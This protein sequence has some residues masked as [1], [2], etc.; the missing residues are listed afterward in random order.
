MGGKY[1]FLE[2]ALGKQLSSKEKIRHLEFGLNVF[3]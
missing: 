3:A 1:D 2:S